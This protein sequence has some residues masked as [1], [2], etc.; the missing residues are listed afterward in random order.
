MINIPVTVLMPVYNAE[1]YLKE[2]IESILNQTYT[3]FEFLIINDGSTDSSKDI[4]L[5]YQDSR[6]RYIEN[7]TN[8][9]LVATLNKGID[10]ARGKYIARM[11]ADDI[12]I[13][14][15]LEKQV[16]FLDS[17]PKYVA[18]S[19]WVE[20][21][22]D[23][24]NSKLLKYEESHDG[25]KVKSLY[26]NHFCH[27]AS[28][29]RKNILIESNLRFD[30]NFIHSED[31]YFFIKLSELGELFN[32][33]ETLLRVRHHDSNVSVLSRNIQYENSLI[34][35]KYQLEQIGISTDN[36]DFNVYSRFFCSSFDLSKD[37][38][39]RIENLI[40]TIIQAN[41]KSNY[42]QHQVLINYFFDKWFS[43]CLNSTKFGLWIYNKFTNSDIS[44]LCK[45]SKI[46][47]LKLL[48]KASLKT[49]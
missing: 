30:S 38:I 40:F 2:A 5:S 15:R 8:I 49:Q 43:L 39:E 32:L 22:S 11:D 3:D 45:I 18:C 21:F 1:S 4:I 13:I 46:D 19:S 16:A 29:I 7:E 48:V 27:G 20:T 36:I 17:Q 23:N 31:Y 24:K 26:Q 25:I 44:K 35:I 41:K 34:V 28:L 33:Q 9:K 14:T 10:L 47:N 42:I 6:I 12:S 37:E